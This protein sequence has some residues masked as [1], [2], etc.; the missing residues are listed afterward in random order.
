MQEVAPKLTFQNLK[1]FPRFLDRQTD[2][3][4]GALKLSNRTILKSIWRTLWIFLRI[5]QNCLKLKCLRSFRLQ[6]E[7]YNQVAC[8]RRRSTSGSLKPI[9]VISMI[10]FRLLVTCES[11]V[12][13]SLEFSKLVMFSLYKEN[14]PI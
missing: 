3:Q 14:F 12:V 5:F 11:Q 2:R 4:V 8:S 9:E 6:V 1:I 13:T 7:V 10:Y